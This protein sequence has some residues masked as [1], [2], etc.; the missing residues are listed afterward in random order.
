MSPSRTDAELR[1]E[2][3]GI[4]ADRALLK[5]FRLGLLGVAIV[6]LLLGG[7]IAAYGSSAQRPEG[8]AER[9]LSDVGDTRR[10]G[11]KERARNDADE[12]GP[13]SLAA[14]LLPKSSTDGRAAFVDLEVGKAVDS[15]G[16]HKVVPFRVHQ[17]VDGSSGP[18]IEGSLVLQ[19]DRDHHWKVIAVD[20]PKAGVEVPSEGGAPAAEAPIGLF[21]GAIG[22]AVLVTLLC[23][24][25]VRLA[26]RGGPEPE[27]RRKLFA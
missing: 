24:V 23:S 18:A 26:G 6:F 3:D 14:G 15:D 7:L 16:G 25:A 19:R 22:V 2:L 10:D 4:A 9:W 20:G 21:V 12:V 13:V 1:D 5:P 8:V 11:V 17:R 27:P